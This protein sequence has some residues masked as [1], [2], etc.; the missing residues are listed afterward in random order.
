MKEV[1]LQKACKFRVFIHVFN[2]IMVNLFLNTPFLHY[3]YCLENGSTYFVLNIL[4]KELFFAMI[5]ESDKALLVMT[6]VITDR[7][8]NLPSTCEKFPWKGLC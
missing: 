2:T 3:D 5:L 4:L 7:L 6:L 1:S 8:I